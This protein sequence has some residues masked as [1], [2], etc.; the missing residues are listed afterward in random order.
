M[1]VS[2]W[3]GSTET[4]LKAFGVADANPYDVT[5]LYT[6]PG[7]YELRI[8]ENGTGGT[9]TANGGSMTIRIPECDQGCLCAAPGDPDNLLG[10]KDG[11]DV[12]LTF[13]ASGAP[14]ATWNISS[15]V[16]PPL[17]AI[18]IREG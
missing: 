7:T 1:R 2:L 4:T 6:G 8:E 10:R 16:L 12:L 18:V 14:G 11:N 17:L 5:S 3:D 9:A 15:L 13:D